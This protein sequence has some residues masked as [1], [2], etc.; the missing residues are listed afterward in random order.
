MFNGNILNLNFINEI[1]MPNLIELNL[2]YVSFNNN[3]V[4]HLKQL[5][6]Q[7]LTICNNST[8]IKDVTFIN[9]MSQLKYILIER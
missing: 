7:S 9:E 8:S 6:L 3:D 1:N 2:D 4:S 5:P